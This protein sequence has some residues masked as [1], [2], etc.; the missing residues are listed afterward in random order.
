DMYCNLNKVIQVSHAL[1]ADNT[2]SG[3]ND[4]NDES[5]RKAC[6][7]I[8]RKVNPEKCKQY[9]CIY[10]YLKEQ[11]LYFIDLIKKKKSGK[12]TLLMHEM[13]QVISQMR[14]DNAS[15]LKPMISAYAAPHLDKKL[16]N[17]PVNAKSSKDRL[18]FNHT[19]L[20][21][22]LCPVRSLQALLAD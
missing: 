14:S 13:Q 6:D 20:T 16:V 9:K 4:P 22:L 15:H 8:L 1:K 11:A 19:E 10:D 2:A 21:Q 5:A 12:T 3:T 18:G 7:N 17:P